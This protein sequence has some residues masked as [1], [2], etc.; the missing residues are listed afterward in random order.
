MKINNLQPTI[1]FPH[2]EKSGNYCQKNVLAILKFSKLQY[3]LYVLPSPWHKAQKNAPPP[4]H[5]TQPDNATIENQLLTL[6][7]RQ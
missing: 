3:N 4:R 1:P 5:Q 2:A 7:T 6:K